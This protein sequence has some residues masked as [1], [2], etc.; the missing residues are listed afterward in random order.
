MQTGT[1]A[2]LVLWIV[3]R[4][5]TNA[6][7]PSAGPFALQDGACYTFDGRLACCRQCFEDVVSGVCAAHAQARLVN[8]E[9][10]ARFSCDLSL[11]AV[12]HALE[13]GATDWDAIFGLAVA[14]RG[15]A[16]C[17]RAAPVADAGRT[18]WA[19]PAAPQLAVCEACFSDCV[20]MTP[21]AGA[22]ARTTFSPGWTCDMAQLKMRVALEQRDVEVLARAARAMLAAREQCAKDGVPAAQ[23]VW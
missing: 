1:V 6:I 19:L 9:G 14:R 8:L 4:Y 10:K 17:P 23:G 7:P 13:G 21:L 15:L 2:P 3:R 16:P 18:A 5:D 11:G 12:A 20:A 22:F